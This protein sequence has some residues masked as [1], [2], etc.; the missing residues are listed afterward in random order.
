[1][2][3]LTGYAIKETLHTSSRSRVYRATRRSDDAPVVVKTLHGQNITTEQLA[4]FRREFEITA[5]LNPGLE[6]SPG[7]YGVVKV[8]EFENTATPAI[9]MEDVGGE[10]LDRLGKSTWSVTDFL[11]LAIQIA[12]ALGQVHIRQII[13]KDINPSNILYNP[14]S[15]VAKIIDFGL[16]TLLPRETVAQ[17]NINVLEGTIAYIS[18][19]QTGRINRPVDYRTDFYS[20]GVTFYELLCGKLPFEETDPLSLI[21]SH[22][23]KQPVALHEANPETPAALSNIIM[24]LLAKNAPDRYQSA[25]GLKSDLIECQ[26]QWQAGQAIRE[27]PLGQRDV[28]ERFQ[29]SQSLFGRE[30]EIQQLLTAFEKAQQGASEVVLV[31]GEAGMGKTSLVNELQIPVARQNG[32]F[33]RGKYI[34]SQNQTPYSG[35]VEALRSLIQQL[36]SESEERLAVMR[37]RI[38]EAIGVNGQV[39]I[40]LVPE[41]AHVIGDQPPLQPLSAEEEQNRFNLTL[42]NFLESFLTPERP[43]V[44]FFDD[45]QWA[46]A[47]SGA[48]LQRFA[49][50]SNLHHL[51]IIVTMRGHEITTDHPLHGS[52]Q[53]FFEERN[54]VTPIELDPLELRDLNRLLAQSLNCP[55]DESASLAEIT[56]AKTGGNPFFVNEF[57]RGAHNDN[58][59]R[60]DFERGRWVWDIH[61]IQTRQLTDNVLDI[62]SARIAELPADTIRLLESAACIGYEF[63]LATLAALS[64]HSQPETA[65]LLRHSLAS[66]VIVPLTQNY[67]L[68]E[69]SETETEVRYS[70]SHAGIQQGIYES[71]SDARR[72][73][74]HWQIGQRFLQEF[75]EAGR[76]QIIFA[77]TNH[78]NLGAGMIDTTDDRLEL[79]KINLQ[80][81]QKAQA[82]AAHEASLSYLKKG[83]ALLQEIPG[84][85]EAYYALA[86]NL[87]T[88]CAESA[89]LN[90]DESEKEKL[91]N[92][93]FHHARPGLDQSRVY[94]IN[95]YAFIANNE[96]GLAVQAGL[97]ALRQLNI[98]LPHH[99]SAMQVLSAF[100]KTRWLLSRRSMDDLANLPLLE[101]PLIERIHGIVRILVPPAYSHAPSLVPLLLM[102]VVELSLQHG[103]SSLSAYAYVGFGF[104]LTVV[105]GDYRKGSEFGKV[106]LLVAEKV[107]R[108]KERCAAKGLHATV[109]Q[110]WTEPLRNT[111]P[112]L[113]D[114]YRA[115][116]SLVGDYQQASN[117]ALIY[118]YHALWAGCKLPELEAEA[119]RYIQEIREMKQLSVLNYQKFYHQCMLNLMGRSEDPC[120]VV[121]ASYDAEAMLEHSLAANDRSMI[122]IS[123]LH[124]FVYNYLFE[125]YAAALGFSPLAKKYLDGSTGSLPTYLYPFYDSL[126]RLAL[127]KDASPRERRSWRKI[128]N[129]HQKKLRTWAI[130]APENHQHKSLLV[131]AELARAQGKVAAARE[132][133]DEAIR[134][135]HKNQFLNEE[136]LAQELAG[137]FYIEQG[138]NEIAEFYLRQAHRTYREWG[139]EAKVKHLE[140]KYSVLFVKSDSVISRE[141]SVTT[142]STSSDGATAID[143]SSVL[144][145]TQ[146]LSSEIV[147][148]K[149]LAS[150]LEIVIENA[151]AEKG[152]LLGEQAGAWMIEAQGAR[153]NVEVLPQADVHPQGLPLSVFSYVARTQENIVLDDA[154]QSGQF[155]RDPYII[156]NKPKSVLCMPMLNQGKLS[157][158]LYLENN[159]T[160]SA[161]TPERLEVIRVLASQAAISIDNARLYFDIKNNEE[162]YRTLFEDS[163]DAIF[164]MTVDAAIVDINQ[165]TLDLFGYTREEMLELSLADIGVNAEQFAGFQALIGGQGSVRDFEVNLARKDGTVMECLLTATLRR[166]EDGTPLAYQGILRDITERKRAARLLEEYSHNLEHMVEDR[167]EE[168]NRA[169]QD[170]EAANAAKSVFLASMSHE[171]RTPMNGIIG[172]TGLLLGTELT[173]QQRDFAE[174]IRASGETLLTI[175]NDILDFSKIES[176]KMELENQPF[177]LREC[178]ESALDLVVTRAAEH[179][180]DLACLIED[181]VPKAISGDV[182]R[183][184]QILLNLLGNA[185]KFTESGEVV[186]SVKRIREQGNSQTLQFSVRDTGIGIPKDR[187]NRLFESF[188]QVDASTTRKYGGTGLG[189]AISKRL[190]ELMGGEIWV[191]SEGVPGRGAAFHFT[192]L[193]EP[194][195]TI[196]VATSPQDRHLLEGKR[197]LVV[198]DNATNRRI[199]RLQVE[200][201]GMLAQDTEF[202]R[203]ALEKIKNGETFDLIVLDMFMPEMDGTMLA[204]EVRKLNATVPLLLFSSMAQN[205]LGENRGLFNAFLAK[206][207]KPSLLFDVLAGIFDPGRR[208]VP[209][210]PKTNVFDPEL[211]TRHPLRILIAEDNAVNQKLAIRMLEQMGYRA[212][213]AS[214]GLEAIESIARQPYDVIFMDVQMPEMDG[215]EATRKIRAMGEFTQPRIVAMTANAMQGDRELCLAAGMD[216][217]ISKPI[218]VNELVDALMRVG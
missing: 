186:V 17:V 143:F 2:S 30:A 54:T 47:A 9:I 21:H 57:L 167:T 111:L 138:R 135:A 48:F 189:L 92:E 216:D 72:Q 38:L 55:L 60:F 7:I 79:A 208:A 121:G 193:T 81:G 18:P 74:L 108:E 136:A 185:V 120:R 174:V 140:E 115:S 130:Y 103:N 28:S 96:R 183:L 8:Y 145:A 90:G 50:S 153:G 65:S 209:T 39:I 160:A 116:R 80:A 78:L 56:L 14:E 125:R 42:Q 41:T 131:D 200:T 40:N 146:A 33:I 149:L 127:W 147:L 151:G 202:P 142:T 181:D 117:S 85:W 122:E 113:L 87:F 141:S 210:A 52:P 212:D 89:Y 109:L 163:R 144:K 20:L 75:P 61:R 154:A 162:K 175:I 179:H 26:R 37:R 217:Y 173:N 128:I 32:M 58:L 196:P 16:S 170:A 70:F 150:L 171:I 176:G 64:H 77:L 19:E 105:A 25:F 3:E 101:D 66:G 192:I 51:L 159:L 44:L 84:Y 43:L 166:A 15:G 132:L 95:M 5:S 118:C 133:Y 161:F 6:G 13:H 29:V 23:A 71:L 107:G 104:L 91:L 172:M 129:G 188:S 83:I 63:D 124:P 204:G 139:A 27:F 148:N 86:F 218:R 206:P 134:F 158:L 11:H 46:D 100:L 215:L 199:F 165:A 68:A 123:Y 177:N 110:H 207:L 156:A 137:R 178:I 73:S 112:L 99:P 35:L 169:R 191:E 184:R 194:A 45:L 62:M 203:E 53:K 67:A 213:L 180:L 94:E 214:N 4:R 88:A 198:D 152:W 205:E 211:A 201:W 49:A 34:R 24:K 119:A 190:V 197:V 76:E 126:V 10:S 195:E 31:S 22:L 36:L 82:T 164:V 155:A 187:M 69:Q 97:D 12:E 157:G 59:I 168:A 98:H 106:S 182:T 1:M 102:K 114:S 93:L